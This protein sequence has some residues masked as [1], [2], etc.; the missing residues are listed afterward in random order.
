MFVA[1][2][3][4]IEELDDADC[5][6]RITMQDIIQDVVLTAINAES[7]QISWKRFKELSQNE[8]RYAIQQL[9]V[10]CLRYVKSHPNCSQESRDV[11][12]HIIQDNNCWVQWRTKCLALLLCSE[13]HMDSQEMNSLYHFLNSCIY[14]AIILDDH[15]EVWICLFQLIEQSET[16]GVDWIDCMRSVEENRKVYRPSI[17]AWLKSFT[18]PVHHFRECLS[19][20][21]E[22]SKDSLHYDQQIHY[23]LHILEGVKNSNGYQF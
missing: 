15:E 23:C 1:M 16:R 14:S 17:S 3:T 20:C 13:L 19:V 6:R 22:T 11:V 2:V 12:Q 4:L 10:I 8:K 18:F 9:L 21:I 5:K 7:I